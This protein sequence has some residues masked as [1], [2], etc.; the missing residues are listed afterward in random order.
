[1]VLRC[2]GAGVGFGF[3]ELRLRV[4]GEGFGL[5]PGPGALT[6]RPLTKGGKKRGSKGW[7]K[8]GSGGP[9]ELDLLMVFFNGGPF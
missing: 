9:I 1:M 3:L 4:Q 7:T 8:V 2:F 5:L 6:S